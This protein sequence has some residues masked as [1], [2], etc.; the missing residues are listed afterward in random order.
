MPTSIQFRRGT[1]AEN[2]AFT[3]ANGELTINSSN[4]SVRVQ[5]G[6]TQGGFELARADLSNLPANVTYTGNL[7]V[8]ELIAG[9]INNDTVGANTFIQHQRII[10]DANVDLNLLSGN[11]VN[12]LGANF[13]T[14][15]L[16]GGAILIQGGQGSGTAIGGDIDIRAGDGGPLDLALGGTV[17]IKGGASQLGSG[18]NIN[19]NAGY[20]NNAAAN[21][22][23]ITMGVQDTS[24]IFIG[25]NSKPLTIASNTTFPAIQTM[26]I[27]G[28]A[29][30]Q[31]MITDGAGNLSWS[32]PTELLNGN[33]SVFAN[34]GDF[35]ISINGQANVISIQ[36]NGTFSQAVW[37]NDLVVTGNLFINGNTT[38]NN[39]VTL[40]VTDPIIQVGGG[41]NGAPLTS[42][43][44]KDRG[45]LENYY[46]TQP[47]Q[48][49]MGWQNSTGKFIFG[50]NVTNSNSV[51]SVNSW[52]D[53]EAGNI[54]SHGGIAAQDV[55]GTLHPGI[56]NAQNGLLFLNNLGDTVTSSYKF[57]YGYFDPD[58]VIL[59]SPLTA[60]GTGTAAFVVRD[61]NT[62]GAL[63]GIGGGYVVTG[64]KI[65][66]VGN[67][68]QITPG[69]LPG[70]FMY[71]CAESNDTNTLA[72]AGGPSSFDGIR[73]I[74]Q[75]NIGQEYWRFG[76]SAPAYTPNNNN[77][78]I[79]WDTRNSQT[80]YAASSTN[81]TLQINSNYWLQQNQP[82]IV[83]S[84]LNAQAI[85]NFN[86]T[87]VF[88][89]LA[90][91]PYN[92]MR[93]MAFYDTYNQTSNNT[94]DRFINTSGSRRVVQV[95]F[96]VGMTTNQ[97]GTQRVAWLTVNGDL[98]N[99]RYGMIVQRPYGTGQQS[100]YFS[101][102][103]TVT[104]ENN[105]YF[106]I[107]CWQ[108][109]G[110]TATLNNNLFGQGSVGTKMS[111]TYI[112]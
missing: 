83:L 64:K 8:G 61:Q 34:T 29:N 44:G 82:R 88:Y 62:I 52:G 80:V 24:A 101:N 32:Y 68:N 92:T 35:S 87:Q 7:T 57:T 72:I 10:S 11:G 31:A 104:L 73:I 56:Q 53:V 84:M 93:G 25:A 86:N 30:G 9:N 109:S 22:G 96:E 91:T 98:S 107:W 16:N 81:T 26:S 59:D 60:T 33:T 99:G 47:E 65:A 23:I 108:D 67:G 78:Y 39:T 70:D 69:T 112:G 74:D 71:G 102:T 103:V 95:T 106:E 18:G 43:D 37:R 1:T 45:V 12:I 89:N 58:Q 6:N 46:D 111:I 36:S 55:S 14:D 75:N 100:Y 19:I 15:A 41:P 79:L 97:G 94:P 38:S 27:Q 13:Y 51:I 66:V 48:A 85:S 40:N 105:D 17:N 5:D 76:G 20:T 28:G 3:G 50:N 90:T 21:L 63:T 54:R 49:F 42:N 110:S 2:D 77:D 4:N